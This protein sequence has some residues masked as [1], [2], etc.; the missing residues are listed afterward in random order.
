MPCSGNLHIIDPEKVS[1]S[2]LQRYVMLKASDLGK[3]KAPLAVTWFENASGLSVKQVVSDWAAHVAEVP[4]YQVDTVLS[5]VDTAAARIQIQ[6]SLPRVIFN[7][8]TQ[9]GEAGLSRHPDFVSPMAC[10]A[11]LYIPTG[12][13]KNEDEL[14]REAL[15]LPNDKLTL[16]QVRRRLQQNLPTDAEFLQRIATGAG[17]PYEKLAPFENRPLRDLYVDAVCGGQV[18][19]FHKAAIQARAEVPMGFQS[20]FAGLLIAAELARPTSMTETLTQIDLMSPFPERPS[21]MR[22]KTEMPH[23]LCA[24]QDFRD[25]YAEK[26]GIPNES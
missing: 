18:M 14:V 5:A 9:K 12:Q 22:A 21:R 25:V 20:A 23:C 17:V 10:L 19:E 8:W 11:C 26:Y 2:N 1:D 13:S 6:A 7:A 15:R 24:D 16:D 3:D 4:G